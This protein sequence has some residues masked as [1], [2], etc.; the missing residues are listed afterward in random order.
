MAVNP[1]QL[2]IPPAMAGGGMFDP[3]DDIAEFERRRRENRER[4]AAAMAQRR[5][6]H[7]LQGVHQLA[8]AA[9]A[10][11]DEYRARKEREAWQKEFSEHT[12]AEARRLGIVGGGQP[13]GGQQSPPIP[14]NVTAAEERGTPPASAPVPS[15]IAQGYGWQAPP[16]PDFSNPLSVASGPA[17]NA[18]I[19]QT[20]AFPPPMAP[21]APPPP[22]IA[23]PPPPP[24]PQP[25]P[26]PVQP[27]PMPPPPVAIGMPGGP[28]SIADL[29]ARGIIPGGQGPQAPRPITRQAY[30]S[31]PLQTMPPTMERVPMPQE[32]SRPQLPPLAMAQSAPE[33]PPPSGPDLRNRALTRV[34]GLQPEIPSAPPM[35]LPPVDAGVAARPQGLMSLGAATLMNDGVTSSVAPPE[36]ASVPRGVNFDFLRNDPRFVDRTRDGGRA[37][38]LDNLESVVFH[39]RAGNYPGSSPYHIEVTPDGKIYNHFRP[40]QVGAHAY[41][42]NP[43]SIGVAYGGAYGSTPT[44]QAMEALRSI[45]TGLREQNPDLRFETHGEAFARTRGT[46]MQASEKGRD[47]REAS[48]LRT[49]RDGGEAQTA[50]NRTPTPSN[51]QAT[52]LIQLAQNGAMDEETWRRGMLNPYL[53]PFYQQ[54]MI[55]EI[56]RRSPENQQK[57]EDRQLD[58]DYKQAKIDAMRSKDEP[59]DVG[60]IPAG[61]QLKRGPDGTPFMERIPGSPADDRS[62]T[63]QSQDEQ[64]LTGLKAEFGYLRRAAEQLKNHDGVSAITGLFGANTPDLS[65]NARNAAAQLNTLKSQVAIGVLQ[66]MRDASKTGGAVGSMT[67]QEWPILMNKIASLERNQSTEQFKKSLQD[68]IDFT[69]QSEARLQQGFDRKYGTGATKQAYPDNPNA[70]IISP[71]YANPAPVP[72]GDPLAAAREAISRGADPAKVRQRLIDNGIDPRGL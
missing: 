62:V 15:D 22:Q 35:P 12:L 11:Y 68:I 48:W 52:G 28:P 59:K 69:N 7:P 45:Y 66:A 40:D 64:R 53:R 16:A 6:D 42:F 67:Q 57:Q 18:F 39:D 55:Q 19:G 13:A 10:G 27:P 29:E 43:R 63:A 14:R 60:T 4:L 46:P 20:E 25:A 30:S 44:P 41:L 8:E 34:A 21:P 24:M 3:A 1:V 58:R 50:E 72:Q 70:P 17:F 2:Y 9:L 65:D 71:G 61:Y 36:A 51:P 37:L 56:Q 32:V 23:S 49:I 54:K 38:N 31:S 47:M 33:V 5:I 26:E